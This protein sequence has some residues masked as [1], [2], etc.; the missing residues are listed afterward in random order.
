[1][2]TFWRFCPWNMT[3]NKCCILGLL[4]TATRVLWLRTHTAS[5]KRSTAELTQMTRSLHVQLYKEADVRSGNT[6]GTCRY[7]SCMCSVRGLYRVYYV[8]HRA[9]YL[10]AVQKRIKPQLLHSGSS[11]RLVFLRIFRRE[12]SAVECPTVG[13]M[14]VGF[15]RLTANDVIIYTRLI[16]LFVLFANVYSPTMF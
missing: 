9:P 8:T 12:L 6:S 15:C 7:E 4:L 14:W 3:R 16:I 11:V 13:Y 1:M 10:V 2:V 5:Y